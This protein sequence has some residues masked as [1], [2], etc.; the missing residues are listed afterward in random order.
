MFNVMASDSGGNP[1]DQV[2]TAISN[3][4]SKVDSLNASLIDLGGSINGSIN[5]PRVIT[6]YE[7][8]R[9][10]IPGDD[11]WHDLIY[12]PN[13]SIMEGTDV[14]VVAHVGIDNGYVK[15]KV[16]ANSSSI[17]WHRIDRVGPS[18]AYGE[19]HVVFTNMSAGTYNFAL[20]GRTTSAS[21]FAVHTKRLTLIII[22][23]SMQ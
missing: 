13:V 2:W 7:L 9:V 8:E 19:F 4:Q 18:Y 14:V 23:D 21:S 15:L 10:F 16:R 3:L 6:L 1:W 17:G 5:P 20:Q 11:G 22:E 12:I